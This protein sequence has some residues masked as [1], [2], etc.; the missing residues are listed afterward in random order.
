M[1]KDKEIYVQNERYD[2]KQEQELMLFYMITK[3]EDIFNFKF[4]E[5]I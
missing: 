2:L 4:K 1:N 5:K 3:D